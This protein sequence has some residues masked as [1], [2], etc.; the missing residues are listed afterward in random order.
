M[1]ICSHG[2]G[3]QSQEGGGTARPWMSDPK[4][5]PVFQ[6][7]DDIVCARGDSGGF[8]QPFFLNVEFW[9]TI[10]VISFLEKNTTKN[11]RSH[12]IDITMQKYCDFVNFIF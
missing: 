4:V 8:M 11:V 6:C 1:A 9:M 2:G 10:L 7:S 3:G 5:Y 12:H